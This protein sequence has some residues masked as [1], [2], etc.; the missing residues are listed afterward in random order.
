MAVAR[1][2][3]QGCDVWLNTP[4][5][6]QEACGTSGMK[7]A[8][9]GALNCSIL[10]GWFDEMYDGQNGW[11]IA[12]ARHED[13][14][15]R[16]EAEASSLFELLEAQ[17]VPLFYDRHATAAIPHRWISRV[18]A[19]LASLG[20]RVSATRMVRD[21]V[22]E[23][24]EP[25]AARAVKLEADHWARARDLAR[26]KADTLAAWDDVKI[27]SVE[28][29]DIPADLGG[30]KRVTAR[31]DLGTLGPE[32]VEVQ[33][34]HGPV[35]S[36]GSMLGSARVVAMRPTG[37]AVWEGAFVCDVAGRYGYTVRVVP[38]HPDLATFAELGR[39]TIVS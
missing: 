38:H 2:F 15:R 5:R 9:N 7:A 21:Y 23:I 8:L 25:L 13:L 32:D 22:T 11:A 37:D 35:S 14:E 29:D 4:R 20:P 24:Y 36:D 39:V 12:S 34:L 1:A 33:V 18:K 10:D 3:Y 6:P 16:D 31:V 26:W 30:S 17:I 28:A 27:V 19:S